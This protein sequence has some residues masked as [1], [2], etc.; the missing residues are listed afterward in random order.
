MELRL[1]TSKLSFGSEESVDEVLTQ[2]LSSKVLPAGGGGEETAGAASASS[3]RGGRT[4]TVS[5]V[6]S[7]PS[8]VL[9]AKSALSDIDSESKKETSLHQEADKLKKEE[10]RCN[11][12]SSIEISIKIEE[13]EEKESER[14]PTQE[15]DV[16]E[17]EE[18]KKNMPENHEHTSLAVDS[19]GFQRRRR[20]IGKDPTVDTDF[21]PVRLVCLSSFVTYLESIALHSSLLFSLFDFVTH[22]LHRVFME[23]FP[24]CDLS[25]YL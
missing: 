3:P 12:E 20:R 16:K 1:V 15:G 14:G 2:S 6:S 9:V 10:K 25:L 8:P 23:A 22:E 13:E 24:I 21:L 7:S 17:E 19:L 4:S 11:G 5:S 18:N